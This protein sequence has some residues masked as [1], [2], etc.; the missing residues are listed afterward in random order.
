MQEFSPISST[1]QV[2]STLTQWTWEPVSVESCLHDLEHASA[3]FSRPNS[4]RAVLF[5]G[6]RD[7]S[8]LIES[9]FSRN[10]KYKWFSTH[11]GHQFNERAQVSFE[12]HRLLVSAMLWKFGHAIVLNPELLALEEQNQEID[13]W[14]ELMKRLQQH[15]EKEMDWEGLPGTPLVDWSQSADIGL[16]FANR[17][18]TSSQAGAIFIVDAT[19]IGKIQMTLK[20]TEILRLLESTMHDR[21]P[22]LPLLFCP[23]RQTK[24]LRAIRQSARYF[25]QMDLRYDLSQIWRIHEQNI[26]ERV[27]LKLILPAGTNESIANYLQQKGLEES[28][29]MV[30]ESEEKN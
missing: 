17:H 16:F 12:L 2:T 5:R 21:A 14:F 30:D 11:T 15:P 25:M 29:V 24:M 10:L 8:W 13:A 26:G 27:L 7:K 19:A 4:D 1:T 20:V 22:G 6:Q 3:N 23:S 9:T 28:F 18:R